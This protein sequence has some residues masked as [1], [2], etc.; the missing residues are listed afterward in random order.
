[1]RGAYSLTKFALVVESLGITNFTW[2]M[3]AGLDFMMLSRGNRRADEEFDDDDNDSADDRLINIELGNRQTFSFLQAA[4]E[5]N[6]GDSER[7]QYLS[8]PAQDSDA[9][10]V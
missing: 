4:R 9:I 7:F 1:M 10:S 3:F 6:S 5:K 2:M 8:N